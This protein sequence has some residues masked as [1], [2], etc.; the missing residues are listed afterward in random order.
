MH[1]HH[2]SLPPKSVKVQNAG[3]RIILGAMKTTTITEMEKT[4]DF[5]PLDARGEYIALAQAEK[6]KRISSHPLQTKLNSLTKNRLKR[7]SLNTIVKSL[8][9]EEAEVLEPCVEMLQPDSWS[10]K[11]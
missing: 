11:C 7:Q 1:L 8:Q 2:G 5:E 3:L 9:K 10:Q 4:A 6:A